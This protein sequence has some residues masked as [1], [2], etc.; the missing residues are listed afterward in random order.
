MEKYAKE[1]QSFTTP[2]GF[3]SPT[4]VLHGT[5]NA[6]T[7]LQSSLAEIVP[8]SMLATILY[9]FDDILLHHSTVTD[10]LKAIGE[11]FKLCADRNI[12]QHPGK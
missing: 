7:H 3:Y 8:S 9:W 6:V 2:D 5:T 12:K 11:L 4:R 10:L 1:L